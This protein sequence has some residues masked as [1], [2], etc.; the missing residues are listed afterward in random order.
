MRYLPMAI[1]NNWFYRYN[2]L[3]RDVGALLFSTVMVSY[4]TNTFVNIF[5][6]YY[7]YTNTVENI[8]P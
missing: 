7:F 4:L 3:R 6:N 5:T 1:D 8:N 2:D